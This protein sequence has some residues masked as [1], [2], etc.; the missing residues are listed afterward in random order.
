MAPISISVCQHKH[1]NTAW[2]WQAGQDILGLGPRRRE[3]KPPRQLLKI[4]SLTSS[5]L[6]LSPPPLFSV[7]K[8]GG[9][10]LCQFR[11]SPPFLSSRHFSLCFPF[12]N[13]K[14]LH[15]AFFFFFFVYGKKNQVRGPRRMKRGG[16]RGREKRGGPR[17]V[18]PGATRCTSAVQILGREPFDTD[19]H[20]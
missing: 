1:S 3:Q 4:S 6:S 15:C 18:A 7:D 12:F 8:E 5:H 11:N 10:S 9:K 20:L 19:F 16:G 2:A 17:F 13:V 14:P